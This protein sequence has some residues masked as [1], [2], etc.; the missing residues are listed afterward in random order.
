MIAIIGAG[1]AGSMAALK[2]AKSH[3]VTLF[4][5]HDTV[6]KPV[7]CTGI[8]T[9]TINQTLRLNPDVVMN[10]IKEAQIIGPNGKGFSVYFKHPENIMDRY[11][12]DEWL[13]QKAEDDGAKILKGHRFLGFERG[14]AKIEV[15]NKKRIKLF[16]FDHILGADGPQS[17]VAKSAELF[18][19]R[20]FFTA[21]QATVRC[22][23]DNAIL[24]YP[25]IGQLGWAVPDSPHT[26][27]VGVASYENCPT[28]FNQILKMHPGKVIDRQAGLIPVY[29]PNL[30][31]EKGNVCVAG[32]AATQVKA[33]TGGGII[34]SMVAGC[35][36]AEHV[37]TGKSYEKLWRKKIGT[38]L[39]LHLKMRAVM[40]RFNANDWNRFVNAFQK[41][42]LKKALEEESRDEP[43]KLLMKIAM[44]KPSLALLARKLFW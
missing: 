41:P 31:T 2:L 18:G 16:A 14:K 36:F 25:H 24:F 13:S 15:V 5:E 33:T 34:A 6:G 22:K 7:Q 3:D 39:W 38:G 11:K 27:R 21:M 30:N 12:F 28:Y 20:T 9:E 4:E 8:V 32:D 44:H 35:A 29:D 23:N 10:K 26:M 42:A 40:N 17:R 1:P 43:V 37:Q 19:K